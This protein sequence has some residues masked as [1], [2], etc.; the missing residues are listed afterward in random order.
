MRTKSTGKGREPQ[1]VPFDR[2]AVI[3]S[4]GISWLHEC[5]HDD[6]AYLIGHMYNSQETDECRS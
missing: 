2:V 1:S 5:N 4:E 6:P 3:L